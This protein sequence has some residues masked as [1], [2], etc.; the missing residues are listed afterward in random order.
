MTRELPGVVFEKINKELKASRWA[1]LFNQ[2]PIQGMV[3]NPLGLVP[4]MTDD[5]RDLPDLFPYQSS[6]YRL[7][8]DLRKSGVNAHIPK[9]EATVQY[10]RFDT[11][12]GRCFQKEKGCFL[13][14]TDIKSAFCHIPVH[15]SDW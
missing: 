1:G 13:A 12:V 3:C 5:G 14:K 10:T 2:I 7:I 15:P 9:Q 11:V 4:K 8:T 6:S